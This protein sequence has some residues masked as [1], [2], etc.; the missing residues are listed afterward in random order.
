[1]QKN[2]LPKSEQTKEKVNVESSS[3]DS[4]AVKDKEVVE[5]SSQETADK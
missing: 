5:S 2:S 1:M 3:N 4:E